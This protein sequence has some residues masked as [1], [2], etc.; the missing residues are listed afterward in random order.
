MARRQVR[1]GPVS[2]DITSG[3]VSV[4][5]RQLVLS[6]VVPRHHHPGSDR[7]VRTVRDGC[8]LVMEWLLLVVVM[9]RRRRRRRLCRLPDAAWLAVYLARTPAL[10]RAEWRMDSSECALDLLTC[11]ACHRHT[12]LPIEGRVPRRAYDVLR[13][14]LQA[15]RVAINQHVAAARRPRRRVLR[16]G[17]CRSL[18]R[19]RLGRLLC[20]AHW[21]GVRRRAIGDCGLMRGSVDEG[22]A[23]D[24]DREK[25]ALF[26]AV[27][28]KAAGT[29]CGRRGRGVQQGTIGAIGHGRSRGTGRDSGCA[30]VQ[31]RGRGLSSVGPTV[32]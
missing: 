18:E 20:G 5:G 28:N 29:R 13:V 21:L 15:A 12:V 8:L 6:Q 22:A 31:C 23:R 10:R 3:R 32:P 16:G 4:S 24:A 1:D 19:G 30:R 17:G 25:L 14:V 7:R 27:G 9:L 11:R 2:V 26:G